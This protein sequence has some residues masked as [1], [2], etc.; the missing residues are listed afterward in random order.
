MPTLPAL[1]V[2]TRINESPHVVILG[3]GAS[4]ACCPTGDLHGKTLPTMADIVDTVDLRESLEQKGY[5]IE[6]NFENIYSKIHSSGDQGTLTEFDNK[7]REYFGALRLP[8]T[9]TLYDYLILSLRPKDAIITFNWDP[10]LPQAFQ[11]W[12]HLGKCLPAIHFLH[13][14]VDIGIDT[15]R[16][17]SCFLTDKSPPDYKIVPTKLLYPIEK[18]DYNTDPFIA[19]QWGAASFFLS[20]AYYV[21]IY[22]YSAPDSDV[23][24]KALLLKAWQE[25]STR[26]LAQFDILD[27]REPETVEKAWHEFITGNHG[28][29]STDFSYNMLKRH[30]RRTCEALAFATLQQQPWQEDPFPDAKTLDELERWIAPI[31][32][33]EQTGKLSGKPHHSKS[34]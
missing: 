2:K 20:S 21:T 1:N 31:I 4:K 5:A 7:I 34:T 23:E 30:P 18:K 25:N 12:R 28:G 10:L 16:K 32:A 27:I 33:E 15:E 26:T 29:A 11:R 9:P 19:D 6:D 14:N 22:G 17:I 24:A 8:S 13:G 3:A